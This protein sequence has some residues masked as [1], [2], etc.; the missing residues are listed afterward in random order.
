ML[1]HQRD[2]AID[3]AAAIF[4][5]ALTIGAHAATTLR[6]VSQS[7]QHHLAF[8]GIHFHDPVSKIQQSHCIGE[9][10][11]VP[12]DH[13]ATTGGGRFEHVLSTTSGAKTTTNHGDAVYQRSPGIERGEFADLIDQQGLRVTI[14]PPALR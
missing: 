4:P 9:I 5:R 3:R 6:I 12:T 1:A 8:V 10:T 13:G 2:A 11:R 14:E 7:G